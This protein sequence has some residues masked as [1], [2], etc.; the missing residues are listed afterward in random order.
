MYHIIK[1]KRSIQSSKWIYASLT[2]LMLEK[3]YTNITITDVAEK[4]II[5]RSTFYRSFDSLDD[6]LR[7]KC[8]TCFNELYIYLLKYYKANSFSAK[9]EKMVFLKP[10]LRY[11]YV[12]SSIIE[13][14]ILANKL[15]IFN[16]SFKNMFKLF[17]PN[18]N[19]SH[20]II[21]NHLDYYIAVRSGVAIN[22]LLQWIRNGQD[23]PPDDLADLIVSHVNELISLDLLL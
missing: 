14:L 21:A 17:S 23:V 1:D 11:W 3:K 2:A 20:A 13:F 18:L 12:D 19:K 10:F 9:E 4:A 15:D 8:D 5:S 7:L 16:E 6:V 22:V